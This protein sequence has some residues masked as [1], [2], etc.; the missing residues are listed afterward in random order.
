MGM[1]NQ[2]AVVWVHCFARGPLPSNSLAN[3]MRIFLGAMLALMLAQTETPA[4][5]KTQAL[6][7][8]PDYSNVRS[9]NY[10]TA[11]SLN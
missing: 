2:I 1:G 8:A 6:K 10:N 11:S 3:C 5:A 7:Y 4:A 9:F